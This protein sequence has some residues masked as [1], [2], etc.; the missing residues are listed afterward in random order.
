MIQGRLQLSHGV[1]Q[2][3]RLY[4][5]RVEPWE[6]HQMA[7]MEMELGHLGTAVVT[8]QTT[9]VEGLQ[10]VTM[11]RIMSGQTCLSQSGML[12]HSR[13]LLGMLM[14]IMLEGTPTGYAKCQKMASV[15]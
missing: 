5:D 12:D 1:P 10:W 4:L 11:Q 7:V 6:G 14:Q 8:M 2:A 9:L 13:K 3:Q 15:E